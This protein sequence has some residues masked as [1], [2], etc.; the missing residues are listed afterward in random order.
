[1]FHKYF[2]IGLLSGYLWNYLALKN[3]A[4][5]V[6]DDTLGNESSVISSEAADYI[7]GGAARENNLFHSF[8]EFNVNSGSRVYFAS[9]PGIENILTR[10]TGNNLSN[11][12]GTLGVDGSANLFLLNPNGIVFGQNSQ[13]D[14]AGSFLATSA[15]SYIFKDNFRYGAAQAESPYLL[16]VNIPVGLQFGS[17]SGAII[18]RSRKLPETNFDNNTD[19]ENPIIPEGLRISPE[20]TL[21]LIGG[22]VILE[23]GYLNT[24]GGK[25]ELGGVGK[26]NQVEL[27]PQGS[28]WRTDY[29]GVTILQIS[30]SISRPELMAELMV[31]AR[32]TLQVKILAWATT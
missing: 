24:S 8:Q 3:L 12:L 6:P 32:L 17:Q 26:N 4:Q 11:I 21:S 23:G 28:N 14:I 2:L 19:L 31:V 18:N 5:I 9:P 7:D 10:V 29:A 15:D 20:Q 27:I 1:M 25:I 22:E 30:S 13:L 16:T